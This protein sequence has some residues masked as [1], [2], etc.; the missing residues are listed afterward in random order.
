MHHDDAADSPA[1]LVLLFGSHRRGAWPLE[2]DVVSL[3][4]SHGCDIQLDAPDVS[5]L[6]CLIWRSERGLE[7]RDC[8]SRAGTLLNGE[9]ASETNLHDGDV[10][11]VGSFCFRVRVP[12]SLTRDAQRDTRLGHLLRSRRHLTRLALAYRKRLHA[13]QMLLAPDAASFELNRK[14][15]GLR[16]CFQAYQ[17]RLRQLEQ[18]ERELARDRELFEE[19][20]HAHHDLVRQ[21]EEELARRERGLNKPSRGAFGLLSRQ[22]QMEITP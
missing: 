18:A 15:S 5:S 2:S 20:K 22:R 6:H 13:A 9:P 16:T 12:A 1:V 14:A 4:R 17:Q 10:L 7:L 19:E 3:G 21:A 11:Q 8:R